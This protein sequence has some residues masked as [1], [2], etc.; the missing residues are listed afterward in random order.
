MAG[1]T[2]DN[3]GYEMKGNLFGIGYIRSLMDALNRNLVLKPAVNSQVN[4]IIKTT[5]STHHPCHSF[6]S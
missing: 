6:F 2:N 5:W 1:E 4:Q 3:F